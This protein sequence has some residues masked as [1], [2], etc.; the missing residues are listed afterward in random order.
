[1]QELSYNNLKKILDFICSKLPPVEYTYY[2]TDNKPITKKESACNIANRSGVCDCDLASGTTLYKQCNSGNEKVFPT[3]PN[4]DTNRKKECSLQDNSNP[5]TC[6]S[7]AAWGCGV[8]REGDYGQAMPACTEKK[9]L[10]CASPDQ[11]PI[12]CKEYDN[13]AVCSDSNK[14]CT[15]GKSCVCEDPN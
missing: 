2:D 9:Y 5:A 12:C 15:V 4:G 1:M 7:F 10:K 8:W 3:N 11:D 6:K 14:W 13:S